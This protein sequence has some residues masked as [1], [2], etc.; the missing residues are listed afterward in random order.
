MMRDRAATAYALPRDP[1]AAL[2]S[3]VQDVHMC[4]LQQEV[5]WTAET[6]RYTPPKLQTFAKN[7]VAFATCTLSCCVLFHRRRLRMLRNY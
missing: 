1:I 6:N 3:L 7:P 4:F 2:T 5:V